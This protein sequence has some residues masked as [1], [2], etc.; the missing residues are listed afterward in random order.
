[1]DQR[2]NFNLSDKPE[3]MTAQHVSVLNVLMPLK[4]PSNISQESIARRAG[5]SQHAVSVTITDLRSRALI[6]VRSGARHQTTNWLEEIFYDKLPAYTPA[7]KL[8]VGDFALRLARNYKDNFLANYTSYKN[9]RG[10]SCRKPL[11]KN[12]EKRWSTVFQLCLDRR[13]YTEKT[14]LERWN[15][16]RVDCRLVKALRVGPQSRVL[17]PTAKEAQ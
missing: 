12:W 17:F 14:L 1:M 7:P 5:C 4:L 11:P 9:S 15:K 10:H 2:D 3:W 13:G 16:V 8:V 6:K